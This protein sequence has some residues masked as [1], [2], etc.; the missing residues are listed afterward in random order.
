[1]LVERHAIPNSIIAIIL[2]I[3]IVAFLV[4]TL[5]AAEML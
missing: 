1:V 5:W 3:A 4:L 2:G